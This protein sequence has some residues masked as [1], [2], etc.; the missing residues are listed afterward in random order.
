MGHFA[1]PLG[2]LHVTTPPTPDL[3]GAAEAVD[4][5]QRLVDRAC[6]SVRERGGIDDNQVVAYDVAHA[7]AAVATGRATLEYGALGQV[8]ARIAAAFVADVV[9]D[10]VGRVSGREALWGVESGWDAPAADFLAVQRDPAVL[11]GLA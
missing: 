10:L 5:A 1:E 3:A 11:A 6:A 9:A 7:A 4:L 2:S 8:E